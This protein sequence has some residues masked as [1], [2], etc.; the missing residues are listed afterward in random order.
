MRLTSRLPGR[1]KLQCTLHG[2]TP[3]A[4]PWKADHR[5]ARRGQRGSGTPVTLHAA[6]FEAYFSNFNE[7]TEFEIGE[8]EDIIFGGR[9]HNDR[10][11]D[12]HDIR[13][14]FDIVSSREE[15]AKT[16]KKF[17]ELLGLLKQRHA[18]MLG[19]RSETMPGEFKSKSNRAG[20]TTFVRP[21]EVIGTLEKGFEIYSR[22]D[23][24][25]DRA[26]FMMF[27]I[28]VVHPFSDGNGRSAR[29]MMNAELAVANESRIIIPTIYRS[30]CLEGLSLMSTHGDPDTLIRTLDFG[31]R[32]VH[33]FHW[34]NLD[35]TMDVLKKT[36]AFLRPEEGD[37]NGI[38]LR[39]PRA[40]DFARDNDENDGGGGAS[41][42]VGRP[43]SD[44]RPDRLDPERKDG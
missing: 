24:P 21:D 8:A 20:V 2:E 4:H 41:G 19:G 42:G 27:M 36:N 1:E 17:E 33:S 38:R 5:S 14:T 32:Y 29:I 28:A 7:G 34:S 30:N 10:P 6:F 9:I 31:Q 39:L 44:V 11:A 37:R 26:V 15:M 43:Q 13:G 3:F 18:L 23:T 25:F 16:P 40:V 22:L 12:A 35:Q